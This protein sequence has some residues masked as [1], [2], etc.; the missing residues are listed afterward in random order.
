MI[1]PAAKVPLGISVTMSSMLLLISIDVLIVN[2]ILVAEKRE[3]CLPTS[4][5]FSQ[6][7]VGC[8]KL[9]TAMPPGRTIIVSHLVRRWSQG[10]IDQLFGILSMKRF[11]YS[12]VQ[13]LDPER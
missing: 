7:W 9:H 8:L 6:E 11:S 1:E 2:W 10:R 12:G 13:Y 3:R 4:A 5:E